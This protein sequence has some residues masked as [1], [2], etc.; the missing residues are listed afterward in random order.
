[1]GFSSL[2]HC[3]QT[4]LRQDHAEPQKCKLWHTA[5][6]QLL[7]TGWG[8]QSTSFCRE[9]GRRQHWLPYTT[10]LAS[11]SRKAQRVPGRGESPLM[12][13]HPGGRCSDSWWV[14]LLQFLQTLCCI[15]I[16]TFTEYMSS[17]E[18]TGYLSLLK[19]HGADLEEMR[20]CILW[21][22]WKHGY[23]WLMS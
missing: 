19:G 2:S 9:E 6:P 7:S 22:G 4:F 15:R 14:C 18:K 10:T 12:W 17:E 5:G 11:I 20:G 16:Y 21:E 1:M 8:Q 3:T 23:L 13:K